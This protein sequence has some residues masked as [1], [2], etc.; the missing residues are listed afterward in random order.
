[1][2]TREEMRRDYQRKKVLH[3]SAL[4]FLYALGIA[5]V[6]FVF[7][8]ELQ[9]GF[10]KVQAYASNIDFQNH[11]SKGPDVT[12]TSSSATT[13]ATVTSA[14]AAAQN[15]ARIAAS[16]QTNEVQT[17][18]ASEIH[19]IKFKYL[20]RFKIVLLRQIRNPQCLFKI[21]L[22]KHHLFTALRHLQHLLR[23]R[24]NG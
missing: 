15:S 12:Q 6:G 19:R 4:M 16:V 5:G 3:K 17:P 18:K 7:N 2:P 8:D 1:M 21:L 11:T 13:T 9:D 14:V 20:Q 10:D 23:C 24:R 22:N